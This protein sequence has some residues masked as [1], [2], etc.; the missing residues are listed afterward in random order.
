MEDLPDDQDDKSSAELPRAWTWQQGALA[1]GRISIDRALNDLD[2]ILQ[3]LGLGNDRP[4]VATEAHSLL[5]QMVSSGFTVGRNPHGLMAL[6]IYVAC[7]RLNVPATLKDVCNC[8][9]AAKKTVSAYYREM[10]EKGLIDVP[11]ADPILQLDRIMVNLRKGAR[12]A[13][14]VTEEA[15]AKAIAIIEQ[16]RKLG[17]VAGKDPAG[18]A[19][20]ALYLGCSQL[21]P[22]AEVARAA[23][24]TEVT[25]RNNHRALEEAGMLF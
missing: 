3:K 10:Y 15:K 5:R 25:L 23:S 7:R 14:Y 18:L 17:V 2:S 4:A 20:T 11:F 19:G 16:A 9:L 13:A 1:K 21:I 12:W 8:S 22:Q 24:V 6:S